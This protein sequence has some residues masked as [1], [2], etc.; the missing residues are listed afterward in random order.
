MR[1]GRPDGR[2]TA[3]RVWP[4]GTLSISALVVGWS[5]LVSVD[6]AFSTVEGTSENSKLDCVRNEN[7]DSKVGVAVVIVIDFCPGRVVVVEAPVNEVEPLPVGNVIVPLVTDDTTVDN[8]VFP[9]DSVDEIDPVDITFVGLLEG[10][11]TVDGKLVTEHRG[12][13]TAQDEGD[14]LLPP[15]EKLLVVSIGAELIVEVALGEQNKPEHMEEV[16]PDV[17]TLDVGAAV[18]AV[19]RMPHKKPEHEDELGIDGELPSDVAVVDSMQNRP[20]HVVGAELCNGLVSD[21]IVVDGSEIH[22]RP[23]H[24]DELELND[25]PPSDVAIGDPMHSKPEQVVKAEVSDGLTSDAVV[26]DGS[27]IHSSPEHVDEL[28]LDDELPFDVA[29]VDPMHSRPE[30]VVETEDCDGLVSDVAVGSPMHNRPEHVEVEVCDGLASDVFV[31]VKMQKRPVH[32]VGDALSVTDALKELLSTFENVMDALT[33]L[34]V[35]EAEET[36]DGLIESALLEW[37]ESVR[38]TAVVAES[39]DP[40]VLALVRLGEIHTDIPAKPIDTIPLHPSVVEVSLGAEVTLGPELKRDAELDGALVDSWPEL[41][42]LELAPDEIDWTVEAVEL[43]AEANTTVDEVGAVVVAEVEDSSLRLAV[44]EGV[45]IASMPMP[46]TSNPTRHEDVGISVADGASEVA[47]E[48]TV[49]ESAGI[50]AL[51]SDEGVDKLVDEGVVLEGIEDDKRD[52]EGEGKDEEV[53]DGDFALD[54]KELGSTDG[55]SKDDSLKDGVMLLG[56]TR[57]TGL[58]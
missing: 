39:N 8:P 14:V 47:L 32:V 15:A 24:V 40:L 30:H 38:E 43:V 12:S 56:N 26:V 42:T 55:V 33:E 35:G 41:E 9:L 5:A 17:S 57:L 44:V 28:E 48:V 49:D 2:G 25:E 45:Q 36:S 21:V 13:F 51:L 31:E 19:G 4:P 1:A 27:E 34:S 37:T 10:V 29:V 20:E 16:E 11:T 52:V 7:C 46:T 53:E 54:L 22:K 6:D 23:E 58:F 3:V 18:V 50:V